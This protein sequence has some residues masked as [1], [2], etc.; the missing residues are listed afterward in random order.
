MID[1]SKL[2]ELLDALP[3]PP[4]P[5]KCLPTKTRFPFIGE[6][7]PDPKA[8]YPAEKHALI[9]SATKNLPTTSWNPG[10]LLGINMKLSKIRV[11]RSP[12]FIMRNGEG[13]PKR[14]KVHCWWCRHPFSSQPIGIPYR[15]N[16]GKATYV[17]FGNFCSFECA[18]A[19]SVESRSVQIN[20]FAGSLLCLMRKDILKIPLSVALRKAPHWASLKAYGGHLSIEEFRSGKTTV[21]AIPENLRLFPV[22][23]NLF[24]ETRKV[25]RA[26]KKRTTSSLF[27]DAKKRSKIMKKGKTKHYRTNFSHV[28]LKLKKKSSK[29]TKLSFKAPKKSKLKLF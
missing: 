25:N 10:V 2:D 27:D 16:K 1:F 20:V 21:R 11:R 22:G 13:F 23:F 9:S 6:V 12:Q 19:F 18:A 15:R 3:P 14:T 7:V 8:V 26:A 29:N 5:V 28:K 24:E 4:K 17:C